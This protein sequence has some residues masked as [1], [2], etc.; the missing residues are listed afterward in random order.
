MVDRDSSDQSGRD[1]YWKSSGFRGNVGD[2]PDVILARIDERTLALQK[3]QE[4]IVKEIETL[5]RQIYDRYVTKDLFDT[6]NDKVLVIQKIV[7]GIFGVIGIAV[8]GAMFKLL[9]PGHTS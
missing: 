3:D 7:F 4:S 6:L 1:A 2:P 5:N 9:F 8:V